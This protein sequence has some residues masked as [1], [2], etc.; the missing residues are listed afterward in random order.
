MRPHLRKPS[1]SIVIACLAL[2][3]SLTGTSIAA[4]RYLITSKN[5]GL[6]CPVKICLRV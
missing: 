1:S 2:F 3:V 4:S 5:S 6:V